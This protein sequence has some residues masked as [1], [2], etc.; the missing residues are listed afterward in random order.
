MVHAPLRGLQRALRGGLRSA[1]R[2]ADRSKSPAAGG[3]R[4][5][6]LAAKQPAEDARILVADLQR[7]RL[8]TMHC[9]PVSLAQGGDG[10]GAM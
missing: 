1:E 5:T 4:Q 7:H 8:N 9:M 2:D 10:L 6:A 3:R